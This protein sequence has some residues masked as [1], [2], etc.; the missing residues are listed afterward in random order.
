MKKIIV[1]LAILSLLLCSCAN[2]NTAQISDEQMSKISER[3]DEIIDKL[4]NSAV[5]TYSDDT[6]LDEDVDDEIIDNEGN[7]EIKNDTNA[8]SQP[9]KNNSSTKPSNKP[10]KSSIPTTIEEIVAYYTKSANQVK[11]DK[12]GFTLLETPAVGDIILKRESSIVNTIKKACMALVKPTTKK[13][14]KGE[15]H[16][17]IFPVENQ[18]W[19]SKLEPSFVKSAKCTKSGNYYKIHI[20]LKDEKLSTLPTKAEDCHTG[21]AIS[22]YTQVGIDN[23]LGGIPLLKLTK[24]A[25]TYHGCYIDCKINAQTEKMVEATYMFNNTSELEANNTI[26]AT[27]EF[28]V[29]QEFTINY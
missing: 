29:K 10:S 18:T 19:A 12:P 3:L 26:S 13:A 2:E 25:P 6:N 20:T 9:S 1:L 28:S 8:G 17:K 24:F 21:K 4:D 11:I 27:V 15:D 5:D 23:V 14:A 7:D 22:V 16:N